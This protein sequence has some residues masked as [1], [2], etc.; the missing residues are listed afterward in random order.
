MNVNQHY[1]AHGV[2]LASDIPLPE[3]AL[4]GVS[5][6]VPLRISQSTELLHPETGSG[7]QC[8]TDPSGFHIA[9]EQVG[10]FQVA[11][12]GDIGYRRSPGASDELVRVPLLGSV[13]AVALHHRGILVMHGNTL[14]IRGQGIILV[15]TKGQGK[16]TL[17]A[18]LVRR[19]HQMHAEDAASVS[20]EPDGT[21]VALRGTR[22]LR[23]WGD[24]ITQVFGADGP[25]SRQIH[26]LSE[27]RVVPLNGQA[28]T[29]A[30]LLLCR[31]Y[32]LHDAEQIAFEPLGRSEAWQEILVHSLV[33][34]FGNELL[35]GAEAAR[36]FAACVALAKTVPC[37]RLRRPRDF[38][39]LDEV[40]ARV[41]EDVCRG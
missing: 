3:L 27:K 29:P 8:W 37:V 14:S 1:D 40:A 13:L 39:R 32:V 34:R 30:R 12:S 25:V 19:G 15:G 4:S 9:W 24:S 20:T 22:Q 7:E 35:K 23:L 6:G 38:A 28:E 16:S 18:A 21:R 33:S 31:I 10:A 17:S 11:P 41:E 36:H 5:E 2:V 26:H